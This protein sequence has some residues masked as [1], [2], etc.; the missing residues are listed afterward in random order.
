MRRRNAESSS[1][2]AIS[3][4]SASAAREP[5]RRSSAPLPPLNGCRIKGGSCKFSDI[6]V[7]QA[8]G[9]KFVPVCSSAGREENL[10]ATTGYRR[11]HV[12]L[13]A[14]RVRANSTP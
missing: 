7:R 9:G 10:I 2:E 5:S 4:C 3:P 6:Y 8:V 1:F 14:R 11:L 13:R 12:G